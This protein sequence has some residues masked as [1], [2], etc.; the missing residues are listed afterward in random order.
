[1]WVV[2]A[3]LGLGISGLTSPRIVDRNSSPVGAKH[4]VLEITSLAGYDRTLRLDHHWGS[5][6]AS[7][8]FMDDHDGPFEAV[9]EQAGSGVR[10]TFNG[11]EAHR[12]VATSAGI[13]L[14]YPSPKIPAGLSGDRG[15]ASGRCSDITR[16]PLD[17]P[18]EQNLGPLG[19]S[20]RTVRPMITWR[21]AS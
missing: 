10:V 20:R 16:L 5:I 1:M 9:A 15:D 8:V 13:R 14:V 12:F 11:W 18:G 2:V 19:W 4:A 6:V 17:N 21:R 7:H 3:C